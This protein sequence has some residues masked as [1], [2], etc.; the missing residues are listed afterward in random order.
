M[1]MST[2]HTTHARHTR[3]KFVTTT[4]EEP[5]ERQTV[6]WQRNANLDD[7]R[8]ETLERYRRIHG[9]VRVV[10]PASYYG[11]VGCRSAYTDA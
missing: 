8:D 3:H 4:T 2:T 10:E 7:L 6:P 5:M 11:S 9:D 1:N